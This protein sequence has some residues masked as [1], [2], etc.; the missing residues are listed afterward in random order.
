[1]AVKFYDLSRRPINLA[2]KT[3]FV[4]FPLKIGSCR[5]LQT[6]EKIYVVRFWVTMN[7]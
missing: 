1:L 6:Y 4:N 2:L 3:Y 7:M 5:N